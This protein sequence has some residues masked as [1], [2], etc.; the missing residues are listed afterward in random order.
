MEIVLKILLFYYVLL[1]LKK[2]EI[3]DKISLQLK[4]IAEMDE[5]LKKQIEFIKELKAIRQEVAN[6]I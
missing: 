4:R 2:I 1:E 5:K 3:Q 6:G